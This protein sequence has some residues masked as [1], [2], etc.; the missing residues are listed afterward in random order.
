MRMY[1]VQIFGRRETL[2]LAYQTLGIVYGDIGTSPLYVFSSIGLE[3]PQEKEIL[4][5]L[6]LIFWT[7]TM[8]ALVK[9]VMIVLR[10]DDHGEGNGFYFKCVPL[11]LQLLRLQMLGFK[12]FSLF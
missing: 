10:A 7:L 11:H 2:L 3:N 6:S 9:Y 1:I 4:G 8:I 12:G 5:C